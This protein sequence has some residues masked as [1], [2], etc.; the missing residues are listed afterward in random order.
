MMDLK[1]NPRE[2]D[3]CQDDRGANN[4]STGASH[5]GCTSAVPDPRGC[6]TCL[7]LTHRLI[8]ARTHYQ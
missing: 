1:A 7:I 3:A 5:L 8:V 2:K 4:G 6:L